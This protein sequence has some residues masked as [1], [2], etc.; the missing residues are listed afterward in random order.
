M[1]QASK[2]TEV[3]CTEV[4]C[5]SGRHQVSFKQSTS[6]I[7]AVIQVSFKESSRVETHVAMVCNMYQVTMFHRQTERF[8]IIG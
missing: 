4:D 3:L 1:S 6:V 8:N 5:H 2:S 7:Q